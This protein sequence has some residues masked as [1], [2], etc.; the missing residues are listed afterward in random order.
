MTQLTRWD[1]FRDLISLREAMDRLVED[2]VVRPRGGELASQTPG[3]LAVDMYE[4]DENVVVKTALAGVDPEDIDISITG[5]TLTIKGETRAEEEV[6]EENYVY[7]ERT[8]GSF[9]RSLMVPVP[10]QAE[11]AEAEFEDGILTLTL[12]KA[13][14]VKPKAIEVKAR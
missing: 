7:R 2:S 11:E 3:A 1:P 4:T 9:C 5:D 14:E 12:P 10:V 6:E 8:Y 13:E